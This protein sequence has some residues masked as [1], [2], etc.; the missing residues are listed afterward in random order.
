VRSFALSSCTHSAHGRFQVVKIK[1]D[2]RNPSLD[3]L[4]DTQSQTL[5]ICSGTNGQQKCA[6]YA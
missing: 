1:G 3:E 4:T 5:P 6:Y 2:R